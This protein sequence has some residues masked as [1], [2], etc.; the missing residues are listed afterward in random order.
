MEK[1]A[2]VKLIEDIRVF[3]A[4]Q[5]HRNRA[6]HASHLI[7]GRLLSIWFTFSTFT[8]RIER[9]NLINHLTDRLV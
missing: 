3:Q 8:C 5:K 2:F 6:T 1:E 9:D 4:S 7:D